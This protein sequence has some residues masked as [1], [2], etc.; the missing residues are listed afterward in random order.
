MAAVDLDRSGAVDAAAFAA[1]QVDWRSLQRNNAE[2][3]LSLA[4]R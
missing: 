1:S 3:W 4:E 2:L